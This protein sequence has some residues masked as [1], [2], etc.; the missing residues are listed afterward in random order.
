[1]ATIFPKLGDDPEAAVRDARQALASRGIEVEVLVD[2]LEDLED[3]E[4]E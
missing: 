1:V 4:S 2:P 3:Q